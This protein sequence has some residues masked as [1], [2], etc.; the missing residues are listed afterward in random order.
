MTCAIPAEPFRNQVMKTLNKYLV[1][2]TGTAILAL[3]ALYKSA[4]VQPVP[5][6]TT[7][8][9]DSK[10]TITLTKLHTRPFDVAIKD[11]DTVI[12]G[13]SAHSYFGANKPTP[14]DFLFAILPQVRTH[15]NFLVYKDRI[16]IEDSN[17]TLHLCV[18]DTAVPMLY[19]KVSASG[20]DFFHARGMQPGK[21]VAIKN[22]ANHRF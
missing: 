17:D 2:A 12:L 7:V 16:V 18:R 3:A 13:M 21:T 9:C 10:K 6:S 5:I 15:S 14:P 20:P 1:A 19:K 11:G 8:F 22:G 4:I